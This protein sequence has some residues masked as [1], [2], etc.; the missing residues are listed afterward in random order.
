MIFAVV[1]MVMPL[2]DMLIL[3]IYA[4]M[5]LAYYAM[6]DARAPI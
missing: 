6:A 5:L 1:L 4:E 2:V 3:L